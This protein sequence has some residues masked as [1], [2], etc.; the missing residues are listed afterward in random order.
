[1]IYNFG[2]ERTS[3]KVFLGLISLVSAIGV[4]SIKTHSFRNEYC[5]ES[6]GAIDK[7]F[8]GLNLMPGTLLRN[9]A[10]FSRVGLDNLKNSYLYLA[11]VLF[12]SSSLVGWMPDDPSPEILRRILN[13]GVS[14]SFIVGIIILVFHFT[15][16]IRKNEPWNIYLRNQT[17]VLPLT[18]LLGLMGLS[19]LQIHKPM[20]AGVIFL[21][22]VPL[23]LIYFAVTQ[24]KAAQPSWIQKALFSVAVFSILSQ[25]FLIFRLWSIASGRTDAGSGYPIFAHQKYTY[26][27]DKKVIMSLAR[28]CKIDP[29]HSYH[30]VVDLASYFVLRETT[31]PFLSNF[32][33][34]I[35]ST[36]PGEAEMKSFV[37]FLAK[38]NSQGMITR[39]DFMPKHILNFTI[40]NGSYCCLS[41][42]TIK[43]NSELNQKTTS[44]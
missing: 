1:L 26:A 44:K 23:L 13:I 7:M 5:P 24:D 12:E 25:S 15:N 40:Q 8:S 6:L 20:Y 14:Y 16:L 28:E 33:S 11:R 36:M 22:S 34:W 27:E 30:V 29:E 21:P 31:R 42:D 37:P 41:E 32:Y 18:L 3:K 38:M 2:N 39:C 10:N 35:L 9:P 17:R 43:S 4:I 19:F